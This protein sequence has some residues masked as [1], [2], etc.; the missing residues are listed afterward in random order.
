[1]YTVYN[2]STKGVGSKAK[3]KK[4]TIVR[5]CRGGMKPHCENKPSCV[6]EVLTHSIHAHITLSMVTD[7]YTSLFL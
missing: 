7:V 6:R 4:H 2:D 5:E 1:M 3:N